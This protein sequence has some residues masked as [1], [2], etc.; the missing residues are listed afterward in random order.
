MSKTPDFNV[1][2]IVKLKS[3]GPDMTVKEVRINIRDEF[4][5][6]YRCQWFAG[7]K[8]DLGDFPQESLLKVEAVI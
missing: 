2:D 6:N 8:L 1:G 7:K 4:T 5:G 3:G